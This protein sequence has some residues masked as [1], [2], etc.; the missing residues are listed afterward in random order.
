VAVRHDGEQEIMG[1]FE[2]DE[3]QMSADPDD[4]IFDLVQSVRL[5]GCT[6]GKPLEDGKPCESGKFADACEDAALFIDSVFGGLHRAKKVASSETSTVDAEGTEH[7]NNKL[8]VTLTQD[9]VVGEFATKSRVPYEILLAKNVSVTF[10]RQ[11]DD[12]LVLKLDGLYLA[13][14]KDSRD[15]FDQAMAF[16]VNAT[17]DSCKTECPKG[18]DVDSLAENV[19]CESCVSYEWYRAN[20]DSL[21]EN[22]SKMVKVLAQIPFDDKSFGQELEPGS[23]TPANV[24][25]KKRHRI[26]YSMLT[27]EPLQINKAKFGHSPQQFGAPELVD[28][29]KPYMDD[30]YVS[31]GTT[32]DFHGDTGL[33]GKFTKYGLAD[34][35][36]HLEK[37]ALLGRLI[38]STGQPTDVEPVTSDTEFAGMIMSGKKELQDHNVFVRPAKTKDIL[39]LFEHCRS[40]QQQLEEGENEPPNIDFACDDADGRIIWKSQTEDVNE[41]I[42]D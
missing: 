29:K 38:S 8:S 13:P 30:R 18:V 28:G 3:A 7:E 20:R 22:P 17:Q 21:A 40:A 39:P 37:M 9:H 33:Q 6:G 32:T 42:L 11:Q 15:L 2:G 41:E 10:S 12:M 24:G 23:K 35:A 26:I 31:L 14:F 19:T 4:G 25:D 16:K 5:F 27:L 36:L 34:K 1:F